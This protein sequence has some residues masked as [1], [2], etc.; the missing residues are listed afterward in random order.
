[1]KRILKPR[2]TLIIWNLTL[3]KDNCNVFRQIFKQKDKIAGFHN[4]AKDRYFPTEKEMMKMGKK[5]FGK[6]KK[7]YEG[8]LIFSTQKRLNNE[9]R[10]DINKLN[11]LN[12]FIKENF[13]KRFKRRYNY[14]E[15]GKNISFTIKNNI[16]I[17]TK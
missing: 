10:G 3:N 4:L 6:I 5:V 16:Y 7:A 9:F 12:K 8:K 11:I 17:M 1:M 15:G 13:P 2:G 14:K